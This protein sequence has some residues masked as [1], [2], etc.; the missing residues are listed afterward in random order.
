MYTPT[1]VALGTLLGGIVG[2]I[3]FLRANFLALGNPEAARNT[4]LGGVVMLVALVGLA[5]AMPRGFPSI[6]VTIALVVFARWIAE[7]HQL[8]KDAIAASSDHDFHSS[9]RV[10]AI[11]LACLVASFAVAFGAITA[12]TLLGTR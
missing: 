6:G 12:L 3:F 10:F 11:G 9:W 5:L 1:Q 2:F 7:R 8:T 4:V